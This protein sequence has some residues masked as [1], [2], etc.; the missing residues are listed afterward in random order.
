[1]GGSGGSFFRGLRSKDIK[2]LF[3]QASSSTRNE[4][5]ES[6]LAEILSE[7]LVEYNERDV[8][9]INAHL[10]TIRDLLHEDIEGSID[11]RF[12]GSIRK[13]TYVDGLSDIDCL[14]YL[15]DPELEN[16]S[17]RQVLEYFSGKLSSGLRGY[18]EISI[19][20]LA[21]TVKYP[22]GT[23]IQLLPAI[24]KGTGFVIPSSRR[25]NEWSGVVRPEKFAD[26]LTRVNQ[27][28]NGKV[29]PTIKLVKGAMQK[30]LEEHQVSG[31]HIESLAIEIFKAY[32]GSTTLKAM[33]ER[34]FDRAKNIVRRPIRDRTGQSIHV[35]DYLG[36]ENSDLREAISEQFDLISRQMRNA[37]RQSSVSEWLA[38]IGETS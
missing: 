8:D 25:A 10:S 35:D 26:Y 3:E 27:R 33:L 2:E 28:C 15:R 7:L 36:N 23:T 34:F 4:A 19:G 17:P 31:Y 11:L 38:A 1:M 14:V 16:M 9:N 5:Y 29:I 21:V 30:S 12:G 6:K 24:R 22:D 18:S 13:H 32:E 37:N 20:N